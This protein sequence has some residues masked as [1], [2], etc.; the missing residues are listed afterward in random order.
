M[1]DEGLVC[2]LHTRA[3]ILGEATSENAGFC[4]PTSGQPRTRPDRLTER[5]EPIEPRW[6]RSLVSR[7]LPAHRRL[8]GLDSPVPANRLD[9]PARKHTATSSRVSRENGPPHS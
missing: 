6:L 9:A 8:G 4:F 3:W 1:S 7:S 5:R 2:A